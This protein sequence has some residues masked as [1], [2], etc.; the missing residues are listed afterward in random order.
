M[1]FPSTTV[2]G[3]FD[4][5]AISVSVFADLIPSVEVSTGFNPRVR[6]VRT[7]VEGI[8]GRVDGALVASARSFR[9]D[10]VL[11]PATVVRGSMQAVI[12]VLELTIRGVIPASMTASGLPV[13]EMGEEAE[14]PTVCQFGSRVTAVVSDGNKP[15][16]LS[17]VA[18]AVYAMWGYPI[19]DLSGITYGRDRIVQW[20][21]AA[22]QEI[23]SQS[24]RLEYFNRSA[25]QVPVPAS[26]RVELPMTVQRV[27]GTA[28]IEGRPLVPLGTRQ[29]VQHFTANYGTTSVPVAYLV[30]SLRGEASDS[31]VI[32][33]H[34]APP[35]AD[36]VEVDLDVTLEPPRWGENDVLASA[37]VPLPHKWVESL[38]MPL[39]RKWA[40]ADALMP[41]DR[42][43]AMAGDIADQ[44]AKAAQM[45]GLADIPPASVKEGG[46]SS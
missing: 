6:S 19:T 12:R 28:S 1:G 44:Y 30:E 32:T 31:L 39:V 22:I 2:F 40:F 26:G 16:T 18:R 27:H 34:L 37:I 5:H 4:A 23:Y 35:P 10:S 36:T 15:M 46:R 8:A 42:R 9:I 21:N 25:L 13:I 41:D 43:Q 7:D 20:C 17:A 24:A 14:Y 11:M 38:F 33:L 45:L 29:Q 3:V